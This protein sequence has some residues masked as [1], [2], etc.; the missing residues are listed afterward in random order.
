MC[1]RMYVRTWWVI[2]SMHADGRPGRAVL[3]HP[4]ARGVKLNVP[5]S[6]ASIDHAYHYQCKVEMNEVR[7]DDDTQGFETTQL[8]KQMK[9]AL[10]D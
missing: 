1:T 3:N 2:S 4:R 10:D 7:R 9:H 6:A 5:S 8:L